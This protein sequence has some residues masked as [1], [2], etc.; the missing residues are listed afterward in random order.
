MIGLLIIGLLVGFGSAFVL[1]MCI[2]SEP[3]ND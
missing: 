2:G 3:K 1:L